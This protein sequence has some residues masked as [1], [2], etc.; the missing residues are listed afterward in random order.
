MAA[1]HDP[2][3]I[4]EPPALNVAVQSFVVPTLNTTDPVGA[5]V[6]DAEVTVTP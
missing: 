2:F 1:G 5:G 3:A 6:P 4:V